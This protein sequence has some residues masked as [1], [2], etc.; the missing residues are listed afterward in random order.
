MRPGRAIVIGDHESDIEAAGAA[1]CWSLHV[2]TGRGD[3]PPGTLPGYLGTIAD[4]YIAA[5]MLVA[6]QR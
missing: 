6:P 2:R 4:L 3:P 1:G 5:K